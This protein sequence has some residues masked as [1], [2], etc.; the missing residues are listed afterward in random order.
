MPSSPRH[1][2]ATAAPFWSVTAKVGTE[3][4]ARSTRRVTASYCSSA[5]GVGGGPSGSGMVSDGSS[6]MLR[7]R[8]VLGTSACP[9]VRLTDVSIQRP[10]DSPLRRAPYADR[11]AAKDLADQA[12]D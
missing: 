7:P 11:L 6:G 3:A 8:T 12:H 10:S 1:S 2:A 4:V 9:V 5:F